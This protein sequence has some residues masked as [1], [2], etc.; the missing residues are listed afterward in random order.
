MSDNPTSENPSS[1]NPQDPTRPVPPTEPVPGAAPPPGGYAAPA[2]GASGGYGPPPPQGPPPQGPPPQGP[3]PG[4]DHARPGFDAGRLGTELQ[5]DAKGL[6]GSLF[7]FSFTN[8]VTPK[9]VRIVY[10]IGIALIVLGWFV[11]MI[12][13][14][15]QSVWGGL[16]VL[17]FGPVF[18]LLY[19]IMFRILL[20]FYVAIVQTAETIQKY[21]HRDQIH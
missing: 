7:D 9:V 19:L 11:A 15:T 3:P 16:F 20:E 4:Q 21:A 13:A 8:Y 10:V 14:F 5:G 17:I 1:E 12:A 18:A 2:P 6:F